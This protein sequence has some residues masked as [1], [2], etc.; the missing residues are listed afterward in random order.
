MRMYMLTSGVEGL[1]STA[2]LSQLILCSLVLVYFCFEVSRMSYI[3]EVVY[4]LVELCVE[5]IYIIIKTKPLNVK[6]TTLCVCNLSFSLQYWFCFALN[7]IFLK[8]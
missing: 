7:K 5:A 2:C 1:N 4:F 8:Q 3:K 6:D